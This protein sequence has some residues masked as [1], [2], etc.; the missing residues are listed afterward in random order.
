MAGVNAYHFDQD[1]SRKELARMIILHEYPLSIVDHIGFRRYSTSL[2]PLFKMVCRNTIK[3]DITSIYDHE[4]EKSIHEIEKNRSRIAITT[5]MWNSQNKKRGFMVVTAHFIDDFWRLQSRV[6]RFIYVPSPHT[7]EVLSDVLLQTLLEW[8]IDRKLSTMTVDNCS[9]NDVV[10]NIILDKLQRSTLVMRGSMLHMRCAAHVLNLI[11]QDGLNVIG[12]C[13]E[14]VRES[15]GFL[16]GSTK[17]RQ[18]FTDTA[19]QLHVECTKELALDCKT[20]WNSTYLMLSTAIEYRD[21]FFRLS[22]RESS[23][24]CIPKEEEWEMTSSICERLA[25][26]YKV[27][28][29]FSE[30]FDCYWNVI[31]GV[32]AVATILDPRHKIELLEYYFPLIYG[33]EAENEIQR[34]RD[35]C[36]E[37]I[38][39]YTSGRMGREGLSSVVDGIEANTFQNILDDSD[40]EEESGVTTLGESETYS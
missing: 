11:V 26:F 35:T 15:V 25:L 19:R 14:K 24:K 32:M 12:S 39:D 10:I 1:E 16:T 8:S 22:Q 38:R 2:Q 13:I 18:R 40:D 5:D 29:L 3:K 4:R 28:E 20:R 9:T 34:V 23:Y 36:Y 17:R 33:D 6:M 21:V 37:M 30:K 31:H 27:T 7:K